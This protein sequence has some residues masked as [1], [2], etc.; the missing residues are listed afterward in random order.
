MSRRPRRLHRLHPTCFTLALGLALSATPLTAQAG[1][2]PAAYDL[3]PGALALQGYDPVAYFEEGG[4]RAT[5]GSTSFQLEHGGVVYRFAS[6]AHRQA[7]AAQPEHFEP[8][9]GG[10]CARAMSEDERVHADPLAFRIGEGR[11]LVFADADDL[12]FDGDWV[13]HEHQLLQRA[14]AAWLAFSAEAGRPAPAGSW[15]AVE[16]YN[17]SGNGLALEGYDPVSYFPEGGGKPLRGQP[18]IEQRHRGVLYRFADERHRELFRANPERFEPQHGGW[19]SYAMGK[20]GEKVE[21]DPEAFRLTDGQ[22]HLFYVSWLNDTRKSWDE[23]TAALERAADANWA[24][25]EAA[26]AAAAPPGDTKT[27]TDGQP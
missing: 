20:T 22:L 27:Q 18:G 2:H 16:G 10:W 11:L 4:G 15:R 24:R 7:F 19:C 6:D 25:L 23:D 13:P 26:H 14:D 1:R 21:V 9:F 5:R 12:A 8:A 17:L 3:G